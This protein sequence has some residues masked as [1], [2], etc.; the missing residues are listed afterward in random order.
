MQ[1]SSFNLDSLGLLCQYMNVLI[2][3]NIFHQVNNKNLL[4]WLNLNRRNKFK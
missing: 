4:P 1:D 3:L 2:L